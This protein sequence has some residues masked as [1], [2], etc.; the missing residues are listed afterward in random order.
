MYKYVKI[1]RHPLRNC[2][3]VFVPAL[4]FIPP[5]FGTLAKCKKAAAAADRNAAAILEK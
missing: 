2:Y 1:E 4:P 5:Y 3:C